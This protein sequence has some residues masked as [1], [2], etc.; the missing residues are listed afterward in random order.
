VA[1]SRYF[2]SACAAIAAAAL[3]AGCGGSQLSPQGP[4]QANSMLAHHSPVTLPEVKGHCPAHGGV[5]VTPCT[6]DLTV[7]SPGPD[8][9]AVRTPVD[10]KGTLSESDNCGGA[11]GIA[12]V[13]QGSG[14]TW[15]VTAG[16][17]TGSCTAE[18]D[19]LS[20]KH[21][22]KLGWAQLSIT[23]SV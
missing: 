8:T 19:Y 23:N 10:K 6:V 20:L 14:N 17:T 18:F 11:S 7:S 3:L 22:K 13:T 15:I 12:T 21:G 5:R 2:L 9:V 16:A 1:T 4:A